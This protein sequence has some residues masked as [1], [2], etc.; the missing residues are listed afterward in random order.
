MPLRTLRLALT[1]VT[2]SLVVF[3]STLAAQSTPEVRPTQ[4]EL[5]TTTAAGKDWITYGGALNNDRYSTLDQINAGNVASLKGAW[6]TRLHSGLGSKYKFEADPLVIDGVMYIPT[7]NDDIFALNARTGQ[8]LWEWNSDIPQQ[9]DTVCCGW[10]NRGVA[11][12]E[13]KIFAGLL[14]GSFVALDQKTG[15]IAWRVQLEDYH[16]GYSMTGA[17]RY[18]DGLVFAGMSGGEFGIRGRVY[19]LDAKTG[20]EAWRFYTVPA[21]GEFGSDTWP[22]QTD[23]NPVFR[24]AYLRGGATVWQAPAIDPQLGMLYFTTGNASPQEGSQR[25][26]DNLFTASFVALDYKTGEYKWHFQEVHHEIWDYDAPSPTVLFDQMY[27]GQMRKGIFEPGKT[28]WVYFLD[29]TNGQPLIGMEEKAVPQESRQFTA[30]T[31]PYPVGDAFVNQCPDPLPQFPLQ[32]CIYTPFWDVPVLNVPTHSGGSNFNPSSYNPNTGYAY[33]F[34]I[35]QDGAYAEDLTAPAEFQAGRSFRRVYSVPTIGAPIN[36]TITALDS[37]TN[38]IVWQHRNPGEFNLGGVT[39]AGGLLF[40]G[41][42][43]GN[44]TAYDVKTGDQLWK[45]QVGMGISAPPMTYSIDGTQYVAVAVGGNRGGVTTLDGDEVWAFAL[46]GNVD[47][48]AAPKP[49][50]TTVTISGATTKL[51][52]QLVVPTAPINV[53][54]TFDGTVGLIDYDFLPRIAQV[55]AGTTLSFTNNGSTIHTATEQNKVFDTGDLAAGQSVDVTFNSPGTFIYQC[56][57]H[58]W[59]VGEVIVQ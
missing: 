13:G 55:P 58:P 16:D 29:R 41:Q 20:K 22:S 46:N 37:R 24:D 26:G 14:D 48:M 47:E 52:D 2:I 45:F 50:Q 15:K 31:Q 34:G 27:N 21:P 8:K 11:A 28:G 42:V 6:M 17:F 23:P 19:A 7:G 36:N 30:A 25:P 1:F 4:Q 54:T 38:K 12:G 53:G 44:M 10:D 3:P 56:T 9:N 59:M 51:G 39:T 33:V 5:T 18:Y 57:P 40:T 32:G 43:D 35:E 49:I